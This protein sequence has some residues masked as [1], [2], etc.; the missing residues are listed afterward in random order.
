MKRLPTNMSISFFFFFLHNSLRNP[1][2]NA[3]GLQISQSWL[4]FFRITVDVEI[5]EGYKENKI[6]TPRNVSFDILI[7]HIQAHM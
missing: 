2:K 6:H 3:I 4:N 7:S 1:M 5:A